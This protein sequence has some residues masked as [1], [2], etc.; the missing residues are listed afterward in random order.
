MRRLLVLAGFVA[1]LALPTSAPAF[2]HVFVPAPECASASSGDNAG[3]NNA[4][5]KA[6]IVEHNPAQGDALPLP[7]AGTPG[8]AHSSN[9]P[10]EEN[11]A[12]AQ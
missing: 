3:G 5:A 4:T 8:A 2:H 10:A 11:C 12:N 9:T 6:A 7:P 1:A